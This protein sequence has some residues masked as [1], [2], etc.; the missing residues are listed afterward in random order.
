[1]DDGNTLLTA[2]S[3]KPSGWVIVAVGCDRGE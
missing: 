2:I 3:A 1:M